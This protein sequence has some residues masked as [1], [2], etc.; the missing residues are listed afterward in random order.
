VRPRWVVG[1][2]W[3]KNLFSS[4]ANDNAGEAVTSQELGDYLFGLCLR[5]VVSFLDICEHSFQEKA[6]LSRDDIDQVELLIALMWSYFDLCQNEK[7]LDALTRMHGRFRQH[8]N[9]LNLDADEMWRLLQARYDQYR[10]THRSEGK[11]DFTY[12]KAAWEMAKNIHDG[13]NVLLEFQ[14]TVFL[15]KNILHIGKAIKDMSLSNT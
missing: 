2:K 1:V 12:K 3:F 14:L 9:D 7:Y 15:Q 8:M 13:P 6:K 5:Q 4:T 11:I 10:Q